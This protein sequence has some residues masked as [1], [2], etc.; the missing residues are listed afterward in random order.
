MT[1]TTSSLP[2]GTVSVAYTATLQASGEV[3]PVS[4]SITAG[5]LPSGLALDSSTGV[6]SGTPATAGKSTFAVTVTD[7][8]TPTA[9][10]ASHQLSI[11]INASGAN[12]SV[13]SGHYAFL[14]SGYDTNGN[15][16]AVAGSFQADASGNISNGIEDLNNAASGPATALTFTG[17]YS[18]GPDNTGMITITN[19]SNSVYTMAVAM[20]SVSGGIAS[21][22]SALEFD[23]SG[24]NMSGTIE[25]QQSADFTVPSV[26]GQYVFGLAGSDSAGARTGIVGEFFSNASGGITKGTFDVNDSGTI[27]AAASIGKTNTY[28]VN[29]STGRGTMTLAGLSPDQYAFYVVTANKFLAVSLN[30]SVGVLSGE[31]DKQSGGSFSASSLSGVLAI[32]ITGASA[33]GGSHVLAGLETFDGAGGFAYSLDDNE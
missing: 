18:I 33:S 19:S 8:S 21:K 23:S 7:S 9:R 2:D 25:L 13:L 28:T 24:F 5:T 1:I 6:I 20:G 10:T 30:S 27:T 4:W 16:V 11:T 12:D 29:A 14:L 32:G 31:M 3:Q 26:T 17:T 15:A 22:G